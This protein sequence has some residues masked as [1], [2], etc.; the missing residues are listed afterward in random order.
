MPFFPPGTGVIENTESLGH[1]QSKMSI[2]DAPSPSRVRT[3]NRRKRYLDLHPEYFMS[4][5]L[6]LAGPPHTWQ[7]Q[8]LT[9]ST[10]TSSQIHSFTI[11][12]S[13]VS[14]PLLSAKRKGGE[15]DTAAHLRQIC[16]GRRPSLMRSP[17]RIQIRHLAIGEDRV[18]RF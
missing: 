1:T 14:K 8:A 16:S 11:G 17:I 18:G 3:K 7:L 6:E 4:A 15:K 10:N 2:D 12:S 9:H 5:N 13:V